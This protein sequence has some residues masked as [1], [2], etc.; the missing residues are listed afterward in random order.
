[1]PKSSFVKLNTIYLYFS[2]YCNLN[3]KHCWIEPKFKNI[4]KALDTREIDLKYIFKALKEAKDIGLKSVKITGGEPFIRADIID[5]LKWLKKNNLKISIETNGTL[6]RERAA[7]AIRDAD[8][9]HI[10][11]SIDGPDRK[12]HEALRK[13]NGS[14]EEAI[15]GVK[16]IRKYNP[17]LSIQIITCLWRGNFK[18]AEEMIYFAEKLGAN[19]IK[20][21]PIQS[22][23]RA[24]FMKKNQEILTVKEIIVLYKKIRKIKIN[25]KFKIIFDIPPAF[26]PLDEFDKIYTC[27]IKNILGIL[28]D[29]T[30]S[31][32]GIGSVVDE[33]NFGNIKYDRI[34]DIWKNNKIVKLLQKE[35]PD[36]L[37]GIC[38]KCILKKLCLGKCRAEAYWYKG[39]FFAPYSFCQQAYEKGLFPETRINEYV[40]CNKV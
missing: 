14:F 31:M 23:A 30:V 33:L 12:T 32:C 1:M 38:G 36:K 26:K 22:I 17:K 39:S 29:G 4:R 9:A 11:V 15:K 6:I 13:V 24:D 3:C 7:R 34:K 25:K 16:L 19:S 40:N 37:E 21:N 20:F 2:G 27:G 5:L 35:I 18:K 28:S 8:V 10:S